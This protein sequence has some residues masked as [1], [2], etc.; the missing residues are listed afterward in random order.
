MSD[1]LCLDVGAK[2]IGVARASTL[3]RIAEP[4][5]TIDAEADPVAAI[6]K[7]IAEHDARTVVVGLPRNMS[8]Q[9]TAQ[10]KLIRAFTEQLSHATSAELHFQDESLTS[11]KA[12]ET[13]STTKK[14]Y[15][16]PTVDELAAV[17]ILEDFLSEHTEIGKE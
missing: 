17:Y 14:G 7:L 15:N 4:L 2:R 3:A 9:E 12:E 1:I 8:G 16:T 10:S 6:V 5:M 13:L 11:V